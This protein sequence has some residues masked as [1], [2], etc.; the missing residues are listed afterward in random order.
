MLR[1][2]GS[3]C[4]HGNDAVTCSLCRAKTPT[5]ETQDGIKPLTCLCN[6][7]LDRHYQR[8]IKPDEHYGPGAS[9]KVY[10]VEGAMCKV[11]V[12][13]SCR[14]FRS[15]VALR[16]VIAPKHGYRFVAFDYGTLEQRLRADLEDEFYKP[17]PG[18]R[19]RGTLWAQ[20]GITHSRH[21]RPERD[22]SA[23]RHFYELH[24]TKEGGAAMSSSGSDA[25]NSEGQSPGTGG[26]TEATAGEGTSGK[27]KEP[28]VATSMPTQVQ[29]S[30]PVP[31]G[32]LGYIIRTLEEEYWMHR[33]L[34]E[35]AVKP[36]H[37][38][39][40]AEFLRKQHADIEKLT[41]APLCG[42]H[43]EL[44]YT[45]RNTIH[46]K[47]RADGDPCMW[48]DMIDDLLK[49]DASLFSC[50]RPHTAPKYGR[51]T[52]VRVKLGKF[53]DQVFQIRTVQWDVEH[54][55]FMYPSPFE[56][57]VKEQTGNETVAFSEGVLEPCG[58]AVG[59][60]LA[61]QGSDA[62]VVWPVLDARTEFL[63]INASLDVETSSSDAETCH[64]REHAI[65]PL[66]DKLEPYSDVPGGPVYCHTAIWR[67]P[68][69]AV[70]EEGAFN[71]HKLPPDEGED[72]AQMLLVLLTWLRGENY[73]GKPL[74]ITLIGHNLGVFDVRVIKRY[75]GHDIF[76]QHFHYRLK[77]T[78]IVGQW[79][80][81]TG[82]VHPG[83]KPG[84]EQEKLDMK[85]KDYCE[86][87]NV[88]DGDKHRALP[89]AIAEARLYK[90]MVDD[91][92]LCWDE[93]QRHA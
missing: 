2:Q 28:P 29:P 16:R 3:K 32:E 17:Y 10:F 8:T 73:W 65:V 67:L 20:G 93:D 47:P 55:S 46:P 66:N 56:S 69:G 44:W 89:D 21:P 23:T 80:Q 13:P 41:S 52:D 36:R 49:P 7:G 88:P 58:W 90:V 59:I 22:P 75:L 48:C 77:D 43:A 45:A 5:K 78:A 25:G 24:N 33:E 38:R 18:I 76:S 64:I 83:F 60:D 27:T 74:K 57:P 11:C 12:D 35:A 86:H 19:D 87:F 1:V 72:A 91:G 30:A 68:E 61:K 62:T 31:V 6:H 26:G 42:A 84:K 54:G 81:D 70:Q 50:E 14:G 85:L 9:G 79:M 82:I 92:K 71:V 37:L 34:E 63:H 15:K 53:K 4:G 40:A 51:G 39:K